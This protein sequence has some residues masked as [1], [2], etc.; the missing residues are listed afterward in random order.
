MTVELSKGAVKRLNDGETDCE[1][2]QP[3]LKV[4]TKVSYCNVRR[5]LFNHLGDRPM[6]RRPRSSRK[7]S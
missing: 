6:A 3:V 4:K 7:L 5:S 2:Y 1:A